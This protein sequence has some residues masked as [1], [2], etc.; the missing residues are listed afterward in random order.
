M[1]RSVGLCVKL[2]ESQ[3]WTMVFVNGDGNTLNVQP[4]LGIS[5]AVL[6]NGQTVHISAT[7][8]N[9]DGM[10]KWYVDV[11]APLPAGMR[12]RVRARHTYADSSDRAHIPRLAV[13]ML[14]CL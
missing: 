4:T 11:R 8:T 10:L 7:Y 2:W 9:S 3:A 5:G 14:C 1:P 13:C 6:T 12:A